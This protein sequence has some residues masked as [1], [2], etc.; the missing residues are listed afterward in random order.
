MLAAAGRSR[1]RSKDR[2]PGG[3]GAGGAPVRL[4]AGKLDCRTR[5]E[6]PGLCGETRAAAV[7]YTL[8]QDHRTVQL[9]GAAKGRRFTGTAH[10]LQGQLVLDSAQDA[11]LR[12]AEVLVSVA[13]LETGNVRR[14]RDMRAMFEADRYPDIRFLVSAITPRPAERVDSML[15]RRYSVAVACG[16]DRSNSRSRSRS[17]PASPLMSSMRRAKSC[18]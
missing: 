9:T 7:T 14:D 12:P 15:S 11:L 5:G 3:F 13:G 4:Y 8:D 1:L 18:S 10:V 17:W 2:W 6:R 16:F